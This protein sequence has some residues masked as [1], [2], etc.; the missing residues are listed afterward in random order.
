M[1]TTEE[2]DLLDNVY[3]QLHDPGILQF[4][5][6]LMGVHV[7]GPHALALLQIVNKLIFALRD[8]GVTI[9]YEGLIGKSEPPL[10]K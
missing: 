8:C 10:A 5:G 9:H 4:C 3:D 2:I 1:L 6:G 7:H